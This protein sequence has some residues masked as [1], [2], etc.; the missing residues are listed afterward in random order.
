MSHGAAVKLCDV[1]ADQI[2][3]DVIDFTQQNGLTDTNQQIDH[4]ALMWS[5]TDHHTP[6]PQMRRPTDFIAMTPVVQAILS[7]GNRGWERD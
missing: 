7:P 1:Q 3:H 6:L 4:T 5:L 2:A